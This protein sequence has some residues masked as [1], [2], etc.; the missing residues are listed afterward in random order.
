VRLIMNDN[1][2]IM[3]YEC[4]ADSFDD[5]GVMEKGQKGIFNG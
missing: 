3:N 4:I 5:D 2:L 1:V